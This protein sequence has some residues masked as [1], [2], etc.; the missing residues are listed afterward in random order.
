[1]KPKV[2]ISYTHFTCNLP[3][4]IIIVLIVASRF[5]CSPTTRYP[6]QCLPE[7][8]RNLESAVSNSADLVKTGREVPTLQLGMLKQLPSDL[9]KAC[10]TAYLRLRKDDDHDSP[11]FST[12]K[13]PGSTHAHHFWVSWAL[14]FWGADGR[15]VLQSPC[16]ASLQISPLFAENLCISVFWLAVHREKRAWVWQGQALEGGLDGI[17]ARQ[18]LAG[19]KSLWMNQATARYI[20]SRTILDVP[21]ARYPWTSFFFL[22]F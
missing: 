10:S 6:K 4:L 2:A 20:H 8:S 9:L 3:L 7:F 13:S 21:Q 14:T 15:F 5:A 11:T 22:A 16:L 17:L 18:P 1:M 19:S 12:H